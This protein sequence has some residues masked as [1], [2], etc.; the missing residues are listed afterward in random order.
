MFDILIKNAKIIDGTGSPY[1]RGN[2]GL[3]DGKIAEVGTLS[4]EAEE[5]IDAGGMVL[6]PGFIDS[7][8]HVDV[9]SEADDTLFQTVEQG[10]TTQITGMCGLSAAPFSMEHLPA[11]LSTVNTMMPYDLSDSAEM[12]CSYADYLIY[13]ERPLG[14]NMVILVGHGTLR[15]SVMGMKDTEPT[16]EELSLMK[17]R[18]REAMEAGAA[19]VSFGLEY[20]PGSYA[21]TPELVEMAKIAAEYGGYIT[22][23][24][25]NE[26]PRIIEAYKELI[27]VAEL[28]GARLILSHH[29]AINQK[30]WGKT[31]MT[32]P[33]IEEANERG[34]EVYCDVYPYLMSSTGLKSRIPQKLHTLGEAKLLEMMSDPEGREFLKSEIMKGWTLEER[35]GTTM[36]GASAAHPEL[37]GKMLLEA[38]AE[39][40]KEPLDFLLDLLRD[41]KLGTNGIYYCVNPDDLE[42]VLRF[43]RTMIG[44]DGLYFKGAPGVH[45]RAF[46]TFPRVLGE[47]VREKKVLTL[48]DAIRKMTSLPAQVYGLDSKGLLRKGYDADL[49]LFDPDTIADTTGFEGMPESGCGII[50]VWIG[51]KSVLKN[52]RFAGEKCG[53]LIRHKRK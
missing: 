39:Q 29:K 49:V 33:L 31:R 14:S 20:P 40:G 48:E 44:T 16:E 42:R 34:V 25:R 43:P 19:G 7:H 23:H 13:M 45:P 52:R 22:C 11:C 50:N 46:G 9:M 24:V 35:F 26:G 21:K 10:I 15:A 37:T 27:S 5:I 17:T 36:I 4:E 41:D 47:Y 51:G 1:F 3:K 32:I 2:V 53:K 18:L 12:R 28:S 38:A 8:S 30:N 6:C